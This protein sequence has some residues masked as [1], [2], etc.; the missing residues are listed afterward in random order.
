MHVGR[1]PNTR[2]VWGRGGELDR[3]FSSL[4]GI[5]VLNQPHTWLEEDGPGS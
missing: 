3:G 4:A 1:G 5:S 2:D